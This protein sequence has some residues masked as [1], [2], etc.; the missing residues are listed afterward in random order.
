MFIPTSSTEIP[1][2]E[3]DVHKEL[4]D[5]FQQLAFDFPVVMQV[6][7]GSLVFVCPTHYPP[8]LMSVREGNQWRQFLLDT[9]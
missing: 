3:I 5:T 4:L 8:S 6:V 1:S 7:V 9:P 2:R